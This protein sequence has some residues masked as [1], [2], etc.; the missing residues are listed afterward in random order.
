MNRRPPAH[1]YGR[2]KIEQPFRED[3]ILDILHI[4]Y[5]DFKR[6]KYTPIA[7]LFS[8][9]RRAYPLYSNNY[10]RDLI[11]ITINSHW[12]NKPNLNEV[13]L[14]ERGVEFYINMAQNHR[15]QKWAEDANH[16]AKWGIFLA[17]IGILLTGLVIYLDL[18]RT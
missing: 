15:A 16:K 1:S 14:L 17:V 6:G 11:N 12:F 4:A 9:M 2:P 5:V 8:I 13:H 3:P 10:L 7:R 18:K